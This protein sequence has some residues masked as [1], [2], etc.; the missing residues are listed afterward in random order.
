MVLNLAGIFLRSSDW[1]NANQH[2]SFATKKP[3]QLV[4]FFHVTKNNFNGIDEAYSPAI[5]IFEFLQIQVRA[6]SAR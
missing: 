5:N 6:N 3:S 4:G 1:S 2:L